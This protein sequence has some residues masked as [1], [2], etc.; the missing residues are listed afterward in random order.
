VAVVAGGAFVRAKRSAAAINAAKTA[1]L[2]QGEV[3][4]LAT[5]YR[6]AI[7][8]WQEAVRLDSTFSLAL[9]KLG[10][11][12]NQTGDFK[13]SVRALEASIHFDSSLVGPQYMLAN[14]YLRTSSLKKARQIIDRA[15]VLEP[16]N[17][18]ALALLSAVAASQG[19]Y[20]KALAAVKDACRFAP[21][22]L[23]AHI[24][25]GKMYF[26]LE[27]YAP[28][29]KTLL[30]VVEKHSG[31]LSAHLAL[32]DFY[33][34]QGASQR[35]QEVLMSAAARFGTKAQPRLLLGDLYTASGQVAKADTAYRWAIQAEPD[36]PRVYMAMGQSYIARNRPDSAKIHYR[37]ALNLDP[38]LVTAK[39]QL[40][41]LLLKEA[42]LDACEQLVEEI[43]KINPSDLEGLYLLGRVQWARG[44]INSAV[45]LWENIAVRA[46][47][48]IFSPYE[49][50]LG[51]YLGLGYY[52]LGMHAE[53]LEVL[54]QTL[55]V[56]PT[57][58]AAYGVLGYTYL[59]VGDPAAAVA[60]VRW[61]DGDYPHQLLA[62][63]TLAQA[64]RPQ[65]AKRKVLGGLEVGL[66]YLRQ[67][68]ASHPDELEA[69]LSL[70]FALQS[71]GEIQ[72][73]GKLWHSL[74]TKYKD[75][76]LAHISLA[77]HYQVLGQADKA[78]A[79]LE[80]ATKRLPDAL[81]IQVGLARLYEIDGAFEQAKTAYSKAVEKAPDHQGVLFA[82]GAFSVSQ[83][84][85]EQAVEYYDTAYQNNP[86]SSVATKHLAYT[87]LMLNRTDQAEGLISDLLKAQ[88]DD[89]AVAFLHGVALYLKQ[90]DLAAVEALQAV[91]VATIDYRF[92]PG[93][94]EL[95][96]GFYLARIMQRN[97]RYAVGYQVI[98]QLSSRFKIMPAVQR[99]DSELRLQSEGRISAG[100]AG[101]EAVAVLADEPDNVLANLV[102]GQSML[103]E[104]RLTE[105]AV[106]LKKASAADPQDSRPYRGLGQVYNAQR[107]WKKARQAFEQILSNNPNDLEALTYI[108]NAYLEEGQPAAA[109]K[110]C[111]QQLD[112]APVASVY[113]LQASI[114]LQMGRY[115]EAEAS[116]K[117]SLELEPD[118][119]QELFLLGR[120]YSG[121]NAYNKAKDVYE[122][123]LVLDE[124]HASAA[125]DLAHIYMIEGALESAHSVAMKAYALEPDNGDIAGTLGWIYY[126]SGHYN[127]AVDILQKSVELSPN[128][129][130][131]LYYLG[132]SQ[133]KAGNSFEAH[134]ALEKALELSPEHSQADAAI[135]VL[136]LL[137]VGQG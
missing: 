2:Q 109:V 1:H 96:V 87:L 71:R 88:P 28:A 54:H 9:Y 12:Y 58:V 63:W 75:A 37:Q 93:K 106:A 13:K 31:D 34:A 16:N 98:N 99:L 135:E 85:Y 120:A 112:G 67:S 101:A 130:T 121:Q 84:Q 10:T 29:E 70:A 97:Q 35:H 132:I 47:R 131:V 104:G 79:L 102:L 68:Y 20:E 128:N 40:A 92:A 80:A 103:A 7:A 111:Q 22:D 55:V 64:A 91:A 14:F 21:E 53:A 137:K 41:F 119:V 26:L 32:A 83:A 69:G 3:Y 94:N 100:Q 77:Y 43:L 82:A 50:D 126:H 125:H 42:K 115:N 45:T 73:A 110:R 116:L 114:L 72:E 136:R 27:Q 65:E 124:K 36:N 17:A 30:Q 59:A 78:Q 105:A 66:E 127:R 76:D 57:L 48:F 19:D 81:G 11:A 44:D 123:V 39:E 108:V 15:V 23:T 89:I 129:P 52:R 18:D 118:Q 5:E 134:T 61:M 95:P 6:K 113:T 107:Q 8:E 49:H 90:Q 122:K 62:L 46:P 33:Q 56:N 25:L 51:Y 4:F 74:A 117:K 38:G 60:A 86:Q 133:Y 24:Q